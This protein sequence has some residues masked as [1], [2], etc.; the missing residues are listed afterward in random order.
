[1]L[2]EKLQASVLSIGGHGGAQECR[3]APT[4][5]ILICAND[6]MAITIYSTIKMVDRWPYQAFLSFN[7]HS[8]I[9][10]LDLP[11]PVCSLSLSFH[12]LSF[13]DV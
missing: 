5:T 1:M 7:F 13:R 6:V 2:C 10:F 9:A 4:A 8:V 11:R 12:T 3:E